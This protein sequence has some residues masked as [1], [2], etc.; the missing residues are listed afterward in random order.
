MIV[1]HSV[2][3]PSAQVAA[4]DSLHLPVPGTV[5]NSN[6][7][8]IAP[9]PLTLIVGQNSSSIFAANANANANANAAAVASFAAS[10]DG[11]DGNVGSDGGGRGD[12][13]MIANRY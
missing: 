8:R 5:S 6:V 2:V 3:V 1:Q 10:N 4:S 13:G 9:R 7:A 12:V 11:A